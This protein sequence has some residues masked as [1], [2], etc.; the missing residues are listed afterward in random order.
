MKTMVCLHRCVAVF[1]VLYLMGV[2]M[3]SAQERPIIQA[4]KNDRARALNLIKQYDWA[5]AYFNAMKMGIA[6][7]IAAHKASP[8]KALEGAPAFGTGGVHL[9]I[10]WTSQAVQAGILY[11]MTGDEDYAQFA[12]DRLNRYVQFLAVE[13]RNPVVSKEGRQRDY[14]DVFDKIALTYDYIQPF[15]IKPGTTVYDANSGTRIPF[16]DTKAQAMFNKIVRY[17]FKTTERA[18]NLEI[19]SFDSILYSA[20]CVEDKTQR[21]AYVKMALEGTRQPGTGLY[22]MKK[23]LIA[24]D[25]IWPES[26][27]Y[28]GVGLEVPEYMEIV[29]RNYPD[30]K[31]FAGFEG[32]LD[33]VLKRLSY[34]YPNGSEH[35]AFGDSHR[36]GGSGLPEY[37]R[38]LRRA[39]FPKVTERFLAA[40]KYDRTLNGYHPN[41]LWT[42]DALEGVKA[43]PSESQSSVHLPY[44]GV[45]IQKNLNFSSPKD[46]GLMYYTGGASYVHSHLSGLDLE[47]YGAGNV[48]SGVGAAG[49]PGGGAS[50]RGTEVF[51]SYFRSYA[52][53]N[54][55][56]VNGESKGST[57][58]WKGDEYNVMDKVQSQAMEPKFGETGVSKDF[59]FSCQQLDDKVNDTRQ[60]RTV[61]MVRTSDTSGYYLDLFRSKSNKE[62]R[63]HDYIYHNIGDSLTLSTRSGAE[64][65]LQADS[66]VAKAVGNQKYED[67][68][69]YPSLALAFPSKPSQYRLFPG[70]H[71]FQSVAY[72]ASTEEPVRGRFDVTIGN[73]RYMHT[74]VPGG[75]KREYTSASAPPI[76]DAAGTYGMKPSRVFSVRQFGEAWNRPFVVLYEP[77]LD[78][79]PTVQSVENIVDA[80]KVVGA[81]VVSHVGGKVITDLVLAEDQ[82]DGS[83][84]N[85]EVGFTGR[86]AIIRT[87][88]SDSGSEQVLYIGDGA[89]LSFE[90]HE[91]SGGASRK[92]FLEIH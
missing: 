38:V 67:W 70:W 6:P 27:S 65:P 12:A 20:L 91:L 90:G 22:G 64:L 47:L 68:K 44:A 60:E 25:G 2:S 83:F 88:K 28:S 31:I 75:D 1:T 7:A 17:G 45:V 54:T 73:K 72:S 63:F 66:K 58:G 39:G 18:S 50:S 5:A 52:G 24:N 85:A 46:H 42:M 49:P 35:V 9:H 13:G 23:V 76:F 86:F 55:V 4:D 26:A 56:V 30:L 33:G 29:D 57:H 78:T 74:F 40:L 3:A 19:M 87:I 82:A 8:A 14:R 21:D 37:T 32:A 84:K 69:R 51:I 80:G 16:D 10:N 89:K 15:L 41:N 11:F 79:S 92:G 36:A 77:S 59:A 61:A 53:H 34:E 62:N 81:R 71:F 48:M 43:S